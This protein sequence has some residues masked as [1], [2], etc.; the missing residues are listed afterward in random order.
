MPSGRTYAGGPKLASWRGF[1]IEKAGFRLST[2]CQSRLHSE[3]K[4]TAAAAG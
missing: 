4:P 1:R 2:A 3:P